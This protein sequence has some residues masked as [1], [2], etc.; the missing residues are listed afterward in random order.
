VANDTP[1]RVNEDSVRE[2]AAPCARRRALVA[3]VTG[4]DVSNHQNRAK[5]RSI[6]AVSE[7]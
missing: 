7:R 4:C 2:S 6:G 5:E 1:G 3:K